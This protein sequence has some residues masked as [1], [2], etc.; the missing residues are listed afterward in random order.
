MKNL[1]FVRLLQS[2]LKIIVEVVRSAHTFQVIIILV[3]LHSV[4][5]NEGLTLDSI[6][7]ILIH[8]TSRNTNILAAFTVRYRVQGP[9]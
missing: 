1:T 6:L 2:E 9:Q 7:H 3:K 5:K 4:G 8:V